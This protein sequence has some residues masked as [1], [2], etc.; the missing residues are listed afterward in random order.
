M[1]HILYLIKRLSRDDKA[2]WLFDDLID[3]IGE[4]KIKQ[5]VLLL[6]LE[7][8]FKFGHSIHKKL[9]VYAFPIKSKNRV[10]KLLMVLLANFY[11]CYILFSLKKLENNF[12]VISSSIASLFFITHL[13]I[14]YFVKPIT[15]IMILWDF[16][17]IHHIEISYIPKFLGGVLKKIEK[18]SISCYEK[19]GLM[20]EKNLEFFNSYLGSKQKTFILP[21]WGRDRRIDCGYSAGTKGPLKC[22]FGGQIT[23]G[24]GIEEL[25]QLAI[26]IDKINLNVEIHVFG[27]GMLQPLLVDSILLNNIQC[28]KYRGVLSREDYLKEVSASD[29]GL[30]MTVPNV[31]VPTYPS[32]VIDYLLTSKPILALVES[33]TDFGEIIEFNAECG[34]YADVS[35]TELIIEKLNKFSEMKSKQELGVFMENSYK[36]FK[37]VHDVEVVKLKILNQL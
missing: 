5:T 28:L 6:D 8:Q 12:S 1:M 21:I 24:R 11:F 35:N 25:I 20:S 14:K 27:G 9:D 26:E 15:S 37:K 13:Y 3:S 31:T 36:F 19:V 30:I 29:I 2:P 7:G 16:F 22:I 10:L 33:S 23:Y 18:I 34:F 4:E 32:K 17:P